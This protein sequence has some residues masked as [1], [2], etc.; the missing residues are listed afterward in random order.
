MA[1]W[2]DRVRVWT[3]TGFKD[4]E[5]HVERAMIRVLLIGNA[6]LGLIGL[7]D[8]LRQRT[9]QSSAQFGAACIFV[10]I[11]LWMDRSGRVYPRTLLVL[12]ALAATATLYSAGNAQDY[13]WLTDPQPIVF[14]STTGVLA[15]SLGGKWIRPVAVTWSAMIIVGVVAA[16]WPATRSYGQVASDTATVLVIIALTFAAVVSVQKATRQGRAQYDRLIETAPVGIV[17]LDL[18]AVRGWLLENQC[19]TLDE[20]RQAMGSGKLN[21]QAIADKIVVQGYNRAA[22]EDLFLNRPASL[23]GS[24][25]PDAARIVADVTAQII[26]GDEPGLVEI[27]FEADGTDYHRVISWSAGSVDRR[28]VVLFAT[29]ITAQKAAEQALSDQLRYKDEFIAS[30]SHE[31]RTPLTA[32]V[33]LAEEIVRPDST[34]TNAEKND[35]MAIV[36]EQSREVADIVEDLLIAA[37]AAGG[38]L[39]IIPANVDLEETVTTTLRQFEEPFALE[40]EE[41]LVAHADQIRV[42]QILRNLASNAIRYGGHNRRLVG[43]A[44][45]NEVVVEVRDDGPAIGEDRRDSIFEPYERARDK[46]D[47]RPDSVGLGLTVARTLAETM[48]GSLVYEYD[49]GESIFRLRLPGRTHD[50]TEIA[51]EAPG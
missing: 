34:I 5:E 32:V 11:I 14:L 25:D 29:D 40:L 41:G 9:T 26:Y 23:F 24:I 31:L 4:P 45:G 38:N 1:S 49:G 12:A 7:A 27:T 48:G 42:R 47:R 22:S 36:A 18:R 28:G 6:G 10:L 19:Q 33:G 30:V 39:S 13:Y 21:P 17:E 50:L 44:T 20:Y 15:L 51:C 8:L 16:R 37:R 2:I 35:L 3:E 46:A 43:F